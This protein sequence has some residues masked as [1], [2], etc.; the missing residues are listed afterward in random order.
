[1]VN[2][3]LEIFKIVVPYFTGGV[4][5]LEVGVE[6]VDGVLVDIVVDKVVC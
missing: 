1:M 4:V 3:V 6:T 2:A 5:G